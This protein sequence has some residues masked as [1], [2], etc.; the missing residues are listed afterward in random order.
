M[1]FDHIDNIGNYIGISKNLDDAIFL[2]QNHKLETAELGKVVI[3]EDQLFY[4]VQAYETKPFEK[5]NLE[6]HLKYIDLQ[7]MVDGDEMMAYGNI[8]ALQLLTPYNEN[9]DAHFFGGDIQKI[10]VK[11]DYFAIFFP[12]DAHQ[13]GLATDASQ[14]VKKV[15]VKIALESEA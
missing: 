13:P 6:A 3:R 9:V 15:V 2:I 10:H 4:L 14:A 8:N 7:L 5:A 11:K 12:N 1:I